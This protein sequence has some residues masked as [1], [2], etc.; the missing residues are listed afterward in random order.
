MPRYRDDEK[1]I[2]TVETKDAD[3]NTEDVFRLRE[4]D[5]KF[6]IQQE[7]EVIKRI[8]LRERVFTF[9]TLPDG[10]KRVVDYN[11]EASDADRVEY[12]AS[13]RAAEN[14]WL[15]HCIASWTG[16]DPVDDAN[17]DRL[18]EVTRQ[19]L[20]DEIRAIRGLNVEE[21]APLSS[22]SGTPAPS[23]APTGQ[24]WPQAGP[25]PFGQ[26][27]SGSLPPSI[28]GPPTSRMVSAP[29]TSG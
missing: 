21:A 4:P 20:L 29:P 3:G 11:A 27:K 8:P 18:P 9:T 22:P 14:G 26:A 10:R 5:P 15:T 16:D 17:V 12:L 7:N 24:P 19:K 1:S 28:G 23:V 6:V 25:G 2:L 13:N